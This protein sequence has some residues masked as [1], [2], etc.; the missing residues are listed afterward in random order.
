MDNTEEFN[1]IKKR[2]QEEQKYFKQILDIIEKLDVA[3]LSYSIQELQSLDILNDNNKDENKRILEETDSYLKSGGDLSNIR[4]Y[5]NDHIRK[6]YNNLLEK[7]EVTDKIDVN[8]SDLKHKIYT[9][10]DMSF[11]ANKLT[12]W[13]CEAA[14]DELIGKKGKNPGNESLKKVI[15]R[16][17]IIYNKTNSETGKEINVEEEIEKLAK[18]VILDNYKGWDD[19]I[20]VELS[21]EETLKDMYKDLCPIW[22]VENVLYE[23]KGQLNTQLVRCLVQ[24]N[25]KEF[26]NWGFQKDENNMWVLNLDSSE[27]A[28]RY[29]YHIPNLNNVLSK[30]LRNQ[31]E[32]EMLQY[33]L[34][35][36]NA[37]R[38]NSSDRIK[39]KID[40]KSFLVGVKTRLVKLLSEVNLE[41]YNENEYK[42]VLELYT[43][44][45][46]LSTGAYKRLVNEHPE[47]KK[48]CQLLNELVTSQKQ[49]RRDLSNI[50]VKNYKTKYEED[51]KEQIEEKLEKTRKIYIQ[52]GTNLDINASIYALK[53]HM[54]DEFGISNIDVIRINAGEKINDNGLLIDAGNLEGNKSLNPNYGGRKIINANVSRA[55]KSACGVLSQYG[56]YVPPKIVQYADVVITDESIVKS[57]YGVNLIRL[58]EGE[59]LFKFAEAK[60][61]DGT[62]LVESEL[63]NEELEQWHIVEEYQKRKD[64]IE[65]AIKEIKENIYVIHDKN[66]K[67]NEKKN[68][69]IAIVDHHI[70]CGA[71]IS[72]CLG[73]DYYLSVANEQPSFAD[74]KVDLYSYN[75]KLPT[76]TFSV[77][78]NHK[79]GN[80]KLPVDLLDWCEKL[81]DNGE[82]DV[83]KIITIKEKGKKIKDQRPFIKPTKDM[84]VFGGLKAPNLFVTLKKPFDENIKEVIIG[85]I[86]DILDARVLNK[87]KI[88]KFIAQS[89]EKWED[90]NARK[91]VK[92]IIFDKKREI[93][94]KIVFDN[95]IAPNNKITLTDFEKE[96][97]EIYSVKDEKGR[98]EHDI[99][100][101]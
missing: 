24:D 99:T 47:L 51:V 40:G 60:R 55:Q 54:M 101:D 52:A 67:E 5:S 30:D 88:N 1:Y 62:Y 43:I 34:T 79:K 37:V 64:E 74:T 8:L 76:A 26:Q 10:A 80:G 89:M 91:I 48:Q 72:Y 70:N 9:L 92:M 3:K 41:D 95:K 98:D 12:K 71:M 78:A 85:E 56:I 93:L 19:N 25:Y 2:T 31:V 28:L 33:N 66:D 58:L 42:S 4:T 46:F 97:K 38:K 82:N 90:S 22:N 83:L 36:T 32:R 45:K 84:V 100:S 20:S 6:L 11:N 16:L 57:R 53:K 13:V 39:E 59:K 44:G 68:K 7:R 14:V 96:G 61:N 86:T 73:C 17:K 18:E 49:G 23:I 27:I 35:F 81:R 87:D 29:G 77:T 15:G 50:D 21:N 75:K 65:E 63:T 94:K 69:Y